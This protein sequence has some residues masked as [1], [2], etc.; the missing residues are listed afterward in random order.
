[1]EPI[2]TNKRS[3]ASKVFESKEVADEE[4]WYGIEQEYTL[5]TADGRAPLGWPTN[6]FPAPQVIIL[7][8]IINLHLY[9]S[10]QLSLYT[11]IVYKEIKIIKKYMSI[12][13]TSNPYPGTKEKKNKNKT[14]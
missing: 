11:N 8:Y 9:T 13:S 1:M 10:I 7:Y 12:F 6:G 5:L 14:K 3:E 2:N 4:P